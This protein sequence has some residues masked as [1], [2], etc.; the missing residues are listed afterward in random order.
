[1]QPPVFLLLGY[2]RYTVLRAL[3]GEAFFMLFFLLIHFTRELGKPGFIHLRKSQV[4][5][6][7]GCYFFGH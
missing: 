5:G 2:P 3:C 6:N 1:M 4:S 7:T